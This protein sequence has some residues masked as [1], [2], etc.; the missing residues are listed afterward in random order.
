MA[1][2][3]IKGTSFPGS[4]ASNDIFYDETTHSWYYWSGSA[5][6][7]VGI[8]QTYTPTWTNVTKGTGYTEV[9]KYT[10]IGNLVT[11]FLSLTLGTSPAIS[12]TVDISLPVTA[13]NSGFIPVGNVICRDASAA[14][15]YHGVSFLLNTTTLR[16]VVDSVSGASVVSANVS[17]NTPFTWVATD[18]IVIT[19]SYIAA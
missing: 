11:G 12:G 18:I 5:W 3:T 13:A 16:P 7:G 1:N 17:T 15:S 9:A 10:V 19:F 14:A 8:T 2:V 4:P 6:I